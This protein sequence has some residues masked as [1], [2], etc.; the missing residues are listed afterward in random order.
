MGNLYFVYKNCFRDMLLSWKNEEGI[1]YR[2]VIV[3]KEEVNKIIVYIL[4]KCMVMKG[5]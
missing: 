5:S 2:D 4:V 1:R 3:F